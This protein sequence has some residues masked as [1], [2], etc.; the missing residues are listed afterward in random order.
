MP[1]LAWCVFSLATMLGATL[2][3]GCGIGSDSAEAKKGVEASRAQI[4][5]QEA[6]ANAAIKRRSGKNASPLKS[7]KNLGKGQAEAQ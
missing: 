5:Q 3:I 1:K 6:G 2:L 4:Q 7:I